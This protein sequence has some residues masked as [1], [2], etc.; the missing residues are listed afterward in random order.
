MSFNYNRAKIAG[1][2]L[3]G[4]MDILSDFDVKSNLEEED[5]REGLENLKNM[6]KK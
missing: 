1:V 2:C 4:F 5:F 3:S 6:A